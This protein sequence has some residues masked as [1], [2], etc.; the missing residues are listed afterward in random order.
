MIKQLV[1]LILCTSPVLA[2][3]AAVSTQPVL[4]IAFGSCLRQD[5]PQPIWGA[6]HKTQPDLFIFMGDNVYSSGQYAEDLREAY[7]RLN[8]NEAFQSFRSSVAIVGT[9]DDHDYGHDDAGAENRIK[10]EAQKLFLDFFEVPVNSPRRL[11]KGIYEAYMFGP[12]GQR[13]QVILLDTRY[14]RSP[15]QKDERKLFPPRPYLPNTDFSATLLGRTQ[16]NWLRDEL[17]KPAEIRLI[18]S[19]IEVLASEHPFEKWANFPLERKKLLE[20]LDELEVSGVLF[21]SGDRH[22]AEISREE[23]E[24]GF[25]LYDVTSSSLNDARAPDASERNTRRVG[26][27]FSE[28]NFGLLQ[29][30]WE[31]ESPRI[32]VEIRDESGHIRLQRDIPFEELQVA[33]GN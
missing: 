24:Q 3:P 18:V 26:P 19:S 17:R 12:P 27:V 4:R 31:S 28:N 23:T 5:L 22:F 15:L 6:I 29:I 13:V 16:W 1:F 21:L 9:W 7:A 20:L 2:L 8:A 32:S 14:H 25:P 33:D 11:Y 30:D 10:E